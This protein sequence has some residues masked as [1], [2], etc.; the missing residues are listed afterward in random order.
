MTREEREFEQWLQ[1][2]RQAA[3]LV[4]EW[5]NERAVNLLTRDAA[6]LTERIARALQAAAE[7]GKPTRR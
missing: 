4:R 3:T 1:W 7:H 5:E 2:V 6:A